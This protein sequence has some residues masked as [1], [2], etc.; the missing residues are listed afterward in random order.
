MRDL[1]AR[2]VIGRPALQFRGE[3]ELV[4]KVGWMKRWPIVAACM[5]PCL[6]L[7]S[8]E[9]AATVGFTAEDLAAARLMRRRSSYP[10]V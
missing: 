7:V 1:V 6:E 8:E 5:F 9:N 10:A 3:V 4:R 2:D